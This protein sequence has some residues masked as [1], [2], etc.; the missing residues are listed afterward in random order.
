MINSLPENVDGKTWR[1][2]LTSELIF[3]MNDKVK[4]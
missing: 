2:N 1:Y 3:N 4:G